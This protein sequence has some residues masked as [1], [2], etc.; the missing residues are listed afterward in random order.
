MS[1]TVKNGTTVPITI[2]N[3]LQL[4]EKNASESYLNKLLFFSAFQCF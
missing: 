4:A 2:Y 3:T 1:L